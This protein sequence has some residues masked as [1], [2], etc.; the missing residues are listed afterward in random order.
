MG[1]DLT[2]TMCKARCAA[3]PPP[4]HM[5]LDPL[6]MEGEPDNVIWT[7]NHGPPRQAPTLRYREGL[8]P[9]QEDHEA[10]VVHYAAHRSSAGDH[11]G[12]SWA[13]WLRNAIDV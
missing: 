13:Q 8:G 9:R 4:G 5:H 7:T 1:R 10:A 11:A 3:G 12:P 6:A 2:D